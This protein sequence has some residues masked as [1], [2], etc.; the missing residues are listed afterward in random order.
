MP[1]PEFKPGLSPS[2][3]LTR[4]SCCFHDHEKRS[5]VL[6]KWKEKKKIVTSNPE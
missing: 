1:E 6:V 3:N 5:K 4:Q 2:K